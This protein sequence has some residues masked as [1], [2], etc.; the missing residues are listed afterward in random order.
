[1]TNEVAY[2][3]RQKS[4]KWKEDAVFVRLVFG[5][6]DFL[7]LL[8]QNKR[9]IYMTVGGASDEEIDEITRALVYPLRS[10][11]EAPV[12]NS[13]ESVPDIS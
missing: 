2:K 1:M 3:H 4:L 13:K 5:S 6:N 8:P 12:Q 10:A 7:Q 9:V 11:G